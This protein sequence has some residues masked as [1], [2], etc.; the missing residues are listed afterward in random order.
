MGV[1][2]EAEKVVAP[3]EEEIEDW[4]AFYVFFK[5]MHQGWH[6]DAMEFNG[7]VRGDFVTADTI[8]TP[9]PLPPTVTVRPWRR[10]DYFHC[11]ACGQNRQWY[12]DK[13][14]WK[15]AVCTTCYTQRMR[16]P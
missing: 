6:D 12:S 1:R 15:G 5:R 3:T 11:P 9:S 4:H 10:G 14:P 7:L 13:P 16:G 2:E 8:P